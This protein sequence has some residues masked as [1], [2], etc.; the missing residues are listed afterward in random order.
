[1]PAGRLLPALACCMALVAGCGGGAKHAAPAP[2]PARI[3]ASTPTEPP[4]DQLPAL[5]ADLTLPTATRDLSA[6][7][8]ADAV[9]ATCAKGSATAL[10]AFIRERLP[11]VEV[12]AAGLLGRVVARI[13]DRC[14]LTP[15]QYQELQSA[16]LV[17]LALNGLRASSGTA[18]REAELNEQACGVMV[19]A[20]RSVRKIVDGLAGVATSHEL[21]ERRG[22]EIG[23][24]ALVQACPVFI[25]DLR[26]AIGRQRDL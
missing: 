17:E 13:D 18:I 1:M 20:R 7:D 12:G 15:G 8:V 10:K 24:K 22:L 19:S 11:S 5:M 9:R 4:G 2:P 23:V 21:Q 6:A 3:A 16:A 26:R 25:A 14:P